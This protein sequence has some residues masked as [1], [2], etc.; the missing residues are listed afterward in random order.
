MTLLNLP[1]YTSS[2]IEEN[3]DY[4]LWIYRE[5]KK[6]RKEGYYEKEKYER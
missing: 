2:I 4:N 5:S 3:D 6:I 1:Y